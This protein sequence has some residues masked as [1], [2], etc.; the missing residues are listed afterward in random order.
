M[1][2]SVASSDQ[3]D[4][5]SGADTSPHYR[6]PMNTGSG[7]G[8]GD[9]AELSGI[10]HPGQNDVKFGRGGDT[11]YHLG[12]ARFRHLVAKYRDRYLAAA[13]KEQRQEIVREIIHRW[14]SQDPPGR[15]VTR[16][17][18]S[19]RK[20][21]KWHD[22]GD[23]VA[24]RKTIKVLGEGLGEKRKR[25]SSDQVCR[26]AEPESKQARRDD[27]NPASA[28]EA[29]EVAAVSELSR[30]TNFN[31]IMLQGSHAQMTARANPPARTAASSSFSGRQGFSMPTSHTNPEESLF[32]HTQAP[33]Q[34]LQFNITYNGTNNGPNSQSA[35]AA[36]A[37]A[38][39][40][41]TANTMQRSSNRLFQVPA[42]CV[43]PIREMAALP[44][45]TNA[46]GEAPAAATVAAFAENGG[47]IPTLSTSQQ[48]G[49]EQ[50]LPVAAALT[51][52]FDSSHSSDDD[53]DEEYLKWPFFVNR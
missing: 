25:Q 27:K 49:I 19:D 36:Y 44:A 46:F 15:F 18:P 53:I 23:K 9:G 45:Q 51:N 40:T 33:P 31:Q 32:A 22:V 37:M 7:D 8:D 2:V 38:G 50:Q 10:I 20:K 48:Q 42:D 17:D 39:G 3:Q 4:D 43:S 11:N 16:D 24:A 41:G 26:E 6:A 52:V 12:N 47:C 21:S 29:C 35:N 34:L 30:I 28:V 1:S 14:R 13:A 5:S